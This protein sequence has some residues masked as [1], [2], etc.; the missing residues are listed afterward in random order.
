MN[1]HEARIRDFL[2]ENLDLLEQGMVLL[3]KEYSVGSDLGSRGYIDLLAKDRLGHFVVIEIKRSNQAARNALHELTKYTALLKSSLGI[4]IERIRALLLSTEWHELAVPFSEHLKAVEVPT[5]GYVLVADENGTVSSVTPFS[6]V[7]LDAPLKAERAQFMW[8]YM[9]K[10]NRDNSISKLAQA[11]I[12]SGITDFVIFNVDYTG[13]SEQ[14]INPHG[15]YFAFSSPVTSMDETQ[16]NAEN[17]EWDDEPDDPSDDVLDQLLDSI[18]IAQD[19]AGRGFPE[20]FLSM[21]RSGWVATVAH[22]NGRYG[23]NATLLTDDALIAEVSRVEGGAGYYLTKTVSPKYL[24]GWNAFKKD[25]DLV[26]LGSSF[27]QGRINALLEELEHE[28]PKATVSL[29][30]YNPGDVVRAVAM[31]ANNGDDRCTP[32]FQLVVQGTDKVALYFGELSWNGK[33][34]SIG[35]VS[36]LRQLFRDPFNYFM[37]GTLHEHHHFFDAACAL[38][39]IECVIFSVTHPGTA[40]EERALHVSPDRRRKRKNLHPRPLTDF[41]TGNPGFCSELVAYLVSKSQGFFPHL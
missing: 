27:W 9:E 29:H 23:A 17:Q 15:A 38:L 40:E 37:V 5:E 20:K 2:A 14:V 36:Y 34:V 4:P 3:G 19:E 33:P 18:H 31:L 35:A 1:N 12:G 25:V 11:A 7:R 13:D 41:V 24:P 10:K 16:R 21:Q 28:Q 8:L 26:L 39:G 22:R 6:P 32:R 30:A